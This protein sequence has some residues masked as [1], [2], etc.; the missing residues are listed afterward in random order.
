MTL[1]DPWLLLVEDSLHDR[2]L[3]LHALRRGKFPGRVEESRDGVEAL[4][5]LLCRSRWADRNRNDHPCAIL[6][7]IAMPVI[8]GIEVLRELK[9]HP[10][11]ADVPVVMLAASADNAD[12]TTCY[13]LGANSYIVKPVEIEMFFQVVI[14]FGRYWLILNRPPLERHGLDIAAADRRG[15]P[16]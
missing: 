8:S 5:L 6:L 2:E 10:D 16:G 14:D 12:L 11:L 15:P 13:A 9:T 1:A 3:T 4:D 7:D